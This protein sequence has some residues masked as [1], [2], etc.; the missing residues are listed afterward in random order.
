MCVGAASVLLTVDICTQYSFAGLVPLAPLVVP[1]GGF[2]VFALAVS[3]ARD[4]SG[5][6]LFSLLVMGLCTLGM[7]WLF[8]LVWRRLAAGPV[9]S[10]PLVLLLFMLAVI[11]AITSFFFC[12]SMSV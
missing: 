5:F 2:I 11:T 4:A 7:I 3:A 8:S 12:V 6:A 10:A 9:V 1:M